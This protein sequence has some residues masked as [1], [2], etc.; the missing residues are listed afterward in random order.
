[1]NYLRMKWK[2]WLSDNK[3]STFFK[4]LGRTKELKMGDSLIKYTNTHYTT[5][6]F[7]MDEQDGW[8]GVDIKF[9][10]DQINDRIVKLLYKHGD[11]RTYRSMTF[12]DGIGGRITNLKEITMCDN[13]G[14]DKTHY[15]NQNIVWTEDGEIQQY[16]DNSGGW[17]DKDYIDSKCPFYPKLNNADM[18]FR[19]ILRA[20]WF[21][22][23]VDGSQMTWTPEVLSLVQTI[24]LELVLLRRDGSCAKLKENV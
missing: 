11:V 20:L 15:L 2:K 12:T 24:K 1:V 19:D 6:H 21:Y 14:S 9:C 8:E 22:V 18:D 13:P 4:N 16:S 7:S 5:Y 23:D 17:Y 3:L 10:I